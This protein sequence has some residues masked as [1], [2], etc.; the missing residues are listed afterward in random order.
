MALGYRIRR[1]LMPINPLEAAMEAD[2]LL[3]EAHEKIEEARLM[4][5]KRGLQLS[6][7]RLLAGAVSNLEIV[8]ASLK[9]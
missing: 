9:V 5:G 6:A 4:L 7:F 3:R 8:K 1:K 2:T